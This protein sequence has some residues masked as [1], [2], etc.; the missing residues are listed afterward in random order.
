MCQQLILGLVLALASSWSYADALKNDAIIE[1]QVSQPPIDNPLSG[2]HFL[3]PQTQAMQDDEFANPGYLWVTAG[4]EAFSD[5]IGAGSCASCHS[6]EAMTG[7][8]TRYP[9]YDQ[10][11]QTLVNLE[12]R[13]NLCRV[14]H[15]QLPRFA[16]E[17][18]AF[19]ALSSFVTSRS[20]DMATNI[21]I[22]EDAEPWFERGKDYFFERRGQ[23]NLACYQ[24]HDE[25]WGKMLRGDRLSQGQ[26]NGFPAYRLEWQ[27]LG[28]LH[29]RLQDCESGVRA[30]TQDIGSEAYLALE[31][32][33]V[34][35]S[36]GL[37][38][39]SPGVRR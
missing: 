13:I 7:V 24:C 3:T 12:G 26:P 5:D 37:V 8:A 33:L 4:A 11:A 1:M 22:T 30:Q 17:S 28:S 6:A 39:E 18:Q 15:Q 9:R 38:L 35:R 16:D 10:R 14:T 29:R 27:G 36:R 25:S 20:Q 32:Y 2:Y 34:W 23:L 21:S 19:L 31:L